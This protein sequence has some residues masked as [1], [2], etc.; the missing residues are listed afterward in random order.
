MERYY[1]ENYISYTR[2]IEDEPRFW[3]R[4]DRRYGLH[5][6]CRAVISRAGRPGR[7]LD[8]GCA[9]GIFPHG[10]RRRGWE[11][12]GVEPHAGAA[13]Y[14]RDRLGIDVFVGELEGV[15]FPV[16]FFDVVTLWDVLE[17]VRDP[18]RTL[19]EIARILRPQGLLVLNL[20]NPD[21]LEARLFGPY[22]AGWDVPR[23]LHVFSR[24]ALERLLAETGFQ[25]QDVS[26]FTGCYHGLVLS[27]RF[28]L[29][30]H[31]AGQW[32]R[33]LILAVMHSWPA[34]ALAL[35]WYAVAGRR[36]QCSVMTVFVRRR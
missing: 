30:E 28:W 17:H 16:R 22:W 15:A 36:N 4:L 24:R 1:P 23:H 29:A 31:L 7:L 18:R 14:A 27:T 6:R 34:R 2:A 13:Q 25:I 10:M 35:P 33:Q 32:L 12:W 20:P 21:C 11:T 3:R 26:S 19:E 5:R 9:T 8:L